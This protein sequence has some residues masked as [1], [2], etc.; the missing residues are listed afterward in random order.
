[1]KSLKYVEDHFDEFEKDTFIDQRFTKRFLDFIPTSK[2]KKYGFKY[3]GT[4]KFIPKKWNEENILEELKRDA[5]FG[6]EK[7]KGERGISSEL[8]YQVVVAWCNILE[9]GCVLPSCQCGAYYIHQ[10]E[11]VINHYNWENEE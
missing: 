1:M 8:M 9:N 11:N 2:W 5:F 3:T 4:E 6:L 7:A 10:F